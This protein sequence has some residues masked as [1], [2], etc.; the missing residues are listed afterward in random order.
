[1]TDISL[2]PRAKNLLK[3]AQEIAES[4]NHSYVGAEHIFLAFLDFNESPKIHYISECL[5]LDSEK[6]REYFF[7]DFDFVQKKQ[8]KQNIIPELQ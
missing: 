2:T 7:E 8:E 5:N 4:N 3:K 6:V 1:M